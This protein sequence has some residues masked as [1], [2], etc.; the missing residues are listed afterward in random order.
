ENTPGRSDLRCVMRGLDPRIHLPRKK[1]LQR[2]WIAGSSPAMTSLNWRLFACECMTAGDAESI[3]RTAYQ[4][5]TTMPSGGASQL[6]R[7]TRFEAMKMPPSACTRRWKAVPANS[8]WLSRRY[9]IMTNFER[10]VQA[11]LPLSSIDT[12]LTMRQVRERGSCE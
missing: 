7:F 6:T 11:L 8:R 9:S 1:F 5:G 10:T 12:L 3:S 4:N 2:G